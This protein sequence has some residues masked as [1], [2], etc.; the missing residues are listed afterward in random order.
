MSDPSIPDTLAAGPADQG[1]AQHRDYLYRYALLQ[2]RD[3]SRAEDVVQET[4]LAAMENQERFSGRSSL[5]TWLTGILKHKIID[6]FRKQ[7]REAPLESG[8]PSESDE[9]FADL[10]FDKQRTD[11]WH[12]FPQTWGD[13][14]RSLEDKRFW[15]VFDQCSKQM[16]P[17]IARAFYMREIMGL[18]TDEICKE[19]SITATNCWVILYRARMSL[20]QCLELRWFSAR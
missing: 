12:T 8:G 4:L 3:A 19:L 1:V 13:P 7:S 17:Q 18:E 10:H 11:H 5:R 15:E 2:L 16:P 9:E 20:R 6:V 14:E